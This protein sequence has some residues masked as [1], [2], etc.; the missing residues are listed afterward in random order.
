M[1]PHVKKNNSTYLNNLERQ[2]NAVSYSS[3]NITLMTLFGV[4]CFFFV[5]NLFKKLFFF[6]QTQHIIDPFQN[7]SLRLIFDI[8]QFW[9]FV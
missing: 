6:F 2:V 1:G 9:L 5:V 3:L 4:G 8:Y 7:C